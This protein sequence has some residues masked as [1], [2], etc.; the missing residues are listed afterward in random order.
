MCDY[1]N[2]GFDLNKIIL[3]KG[4]ED[5]LVVSGRDDLAEDSKYEKGAFFGK[6]SLDNAS[7]KENEVPE[8]R[9]LEVGFKIVFMLD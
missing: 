1:T 8:F 6:D 3:S 2:V 7:A 9:N 4:I 5:P